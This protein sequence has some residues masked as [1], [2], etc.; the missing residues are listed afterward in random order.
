MS[1]LFEQ[2]TRCVVLV[3]TKAIQQKAY[4]SF[5]IPRNIVFHVA[6]SNKLSKPLG[7]FCRLT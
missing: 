3:T 4:S 2:Y 5:N 6:I 1:Q 7:I